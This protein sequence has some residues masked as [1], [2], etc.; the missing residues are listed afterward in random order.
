VEEVAKLES[1]AYDQKMRSIVKRTQ[2]KRKIT[3]ENN[4]LCTSEEVIIDTKKENMIELFLAGL[5]ILHK[6]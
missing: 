1:F 3:L 5:T 6:V 2:R 4:V